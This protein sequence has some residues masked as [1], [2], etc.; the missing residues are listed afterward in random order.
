MISLQFRIQMVFNCLIQYLFVFVDC[1][2]ESEAKKKKKTGNNSK[3]ARN[4]K[5]VKN[6]IVRR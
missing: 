5:N 2:V 4:K 3:K 1:F 6:I